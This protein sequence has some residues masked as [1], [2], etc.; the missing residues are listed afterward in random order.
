MSRALTGIAIAAALLAG[1]AAA[2]VAAQATAPADGRHAAV[3]P[4]SA[5]AASATIAA[6]AATG[7][8]TAHAGRLSLAG[9]LLY[10]LP[11]EAVA[12]RTL[13]AL[14]QLRLG[15]LNNE[16]ASA[17]QTKLNAGPHE[18]MIRAGAA[19]RRVVGEQRYREQELGLEHSLRWFGKA[20]QDRKIGAQGVT[21]AEAQRADAWHEACRM[22]MHDWYDAL[23]A[24][25]AVQRLAE[26][27]ALVQQL[28]TVAERRVK[29]GD[30]PAL[31]LMQADTEL[32]RFEAQVEQARQDV[33]L[34][35]T[36]LA[37][38]YNNLPEPQAERLPEPQRAQD[39]LPTQLAR[40]TEDNHELELAQV[41]AQLY[42]LRS[43]RA[44]SE[45]MPDPTLAFHTGRERDGQER[46]LGLT[47]SIPLPGAARSAETTAATVR[48]RMA[49]ERVSQVKAKVQLDARRAVA[50]QRHSYQIWTSLRDVAEQSK[51]QAQ[52]MDRAY[53]SGEASLTDALLVRRQA[54]DAALAAQTAQITALAAS[55][56]VQL[57]AHALWSID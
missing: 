36:L 56:R 42:A 33:A 7:S 52:L 39:D 38:T 45:R 11:P 43:R 26:Q 22:L 18:W 57:D 6:P 28:K 2:T 51:R 53:Q 32:R 8:A 50:E 20:E 44:A 24:Q 19:Q 40:I 4:R 10:A 21:L 37:T 17:E 30:S 35:L 41:E 3:A 48:A 12:R 29:A 47:L 5:V 34:A 25:A 16:L 46:T 55:A 9:D 23:R 54:L 1:T 14:P 31:E 49:D 15:A 13:A 27:H